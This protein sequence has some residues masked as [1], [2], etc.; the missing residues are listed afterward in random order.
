MNEPITLV[1]YLGKDPEIRKTAECVFE[2]TR[3]NA[4]AEMDETYLA[5]TRERAYIVLSLATHDAR[6][7]TSWHRL[8]VWGGDQIC[9][10][11]I[12][13]ARQGDLVRVTGRPDTHRFETEEGPRELQQL[14]VQDFK[15]LKRSR[16]RLP[17]EIP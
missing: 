17:P 14:I 1:G 4:I 15:T 5:R 7:R 2:V 11:N 13:F 9:H 10:R 3:Y 6:R 16:K 8:V 12:R